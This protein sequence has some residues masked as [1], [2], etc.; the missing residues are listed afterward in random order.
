[1]ETLSWEA[2]QAHLSE[3]APAALSMGGTK[4]VQLGYAPEDGRMF[5]RLPVVAGTHVPPARFA[6]IRL[7]IRSVDSKPVLEVST[8]TDGL[9]REF[10]RFAGLL[11]EDFEKPGRSAIEAFDAAI[12][13][14]QELTSKKRL[15][16]PEE[17]LGLWGELLFLE[18][19]IEKMKGAAITAWTG[20]NRDLPERHDFR[21]PGLDI[22]I[23]TTRMSRRS[24]VIHGLGQLSSGLGHDLYVLSIRLEGAGAGHGRSLGEMVKRIEWRLGGDRPAKRSFEEKLRAANFDSADVAS[25]SERFKL[26]DAPMLIRVDDSIPRIVSATLNNA[27]PAALAGRISEVS[28]RVDVEGFGMA[29]GTA[30][31]A[32]ILG[33]LALE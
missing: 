23:K 18:A 32:A 13:R 12:E 7:D 26:A 3:G 17:Q 8:V 33:D 5:V 31:F 9:F 19:L 4:G 30:S 11:T 16:S 20:R 24:H 10:H 21:L 22:E 1:V 14:W 6:E 28:Y 2:L 27:M 15:L 29:H 25:Y